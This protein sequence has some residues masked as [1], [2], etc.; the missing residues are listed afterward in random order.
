MNHFRYL[1]KRHSNI[2][3]YLI[4]TNQFFRVTPCNTFYF[5]QKIL[6]RC[7]WRVQSGRGQEG[8]VS[9]RTHRCACLLNRLCALLCSFFRYP[10]SVPVL[11][12][13]RELGCQDR[14]FSLVHSALQK[15]FRY[16]HSLSRCLPHEPPRAP[17]S[18][19]DVRGCVGFGPL[20]FVLVSE[21]RTLFLPF[22]S[23][24]QFHCR[25]A[26]PTPQPSSSPPSHPPPPALPV[27]SS[28]TGTTRLSNSLERTT[29]VLRSRAN[30]RHSC[31]L[32]KIN[33]RSETY[34]SIAGKF[35]PSVILRVRP[36]NF[37]F[38]V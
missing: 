13:N 2:E 24:R 36:L 18:G 29:L 9:N 15:L 12:C 37:F 11:L 28:L 25:P 19:F 20:K 16:F 27:V 1:N 8:F 38:C 10:P 7:H 14:R 22:P 35:I 30:T 32:R 5:F 17:V 34:I 31:V 21:R 33:P 6:S 4:S 3:P 26:Q 23:H